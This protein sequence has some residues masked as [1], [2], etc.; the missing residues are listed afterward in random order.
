MLDFFIYLLLF[1]SIQDNELVP[2]HLP[3]VI[4][5]FFYYH[6]GLMYLNISGRFNLLELIQL[7]EA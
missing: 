1:T 7:K 6:Y 3:M 2:Y 5:S 4:D